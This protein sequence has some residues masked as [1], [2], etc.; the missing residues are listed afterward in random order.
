MSYLIPFLRYNYQREGN[1]EAVI[2]KAEYHSVSAANVIYRQI[3]SKANC[4]EKR[5]EPCILLL[6][7]NLGC[8][9]PL[10]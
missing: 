9:P 3:P 6:G 5:Q 10:G 7:K 1:H 8:L 2:E 4:D